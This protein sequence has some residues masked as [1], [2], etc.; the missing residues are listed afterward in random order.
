VAG[1]ARQRHQ[2]LGFG[3]GQAPLIGKVLEYALVLPRCRRLRRQRAAGR[4]RG[5]DVCGPALAA[6]G[7]TCDAW[8][9]TGGVRPHRQRPGLD[10]RQAQR[11]RAGGQQCGQG[12]GG[13]AGVLQGCVPLGRPG[14]GQVLDDARERVGAQIGVGTERRQR[15]QPRHPQPGRA[16]PGELGVQEGAVEGQ[17]VRY[18]QGS[19]HQPQQRPRDLRERR[20][21]RDV[22]VADPVQ[23]LVVPRHPPL[24]VDQGGKLLQH[25]A[26]GPQPH[27]RDLAYPVAARRIQAGGL[28]ID[29]RVLNPSGIDPI[30]SPPQ[31]HRLEHRS[32]RPFPTYHTTQRPPSSPITRPE[33]PPGS[34]GRPY[35]DGTNLGADRPAAGARVALPRR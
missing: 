25:R 21:A 33:A 7:K 10:A 1:R 12:P 26:V 17:V 2:L 35:T 13:V 15:A 4:Q 20:R 27:R 32:T 28:H 31:E 16:G 3:S 30:K 18:H 5:A 6:A 8:L 14:P 11:L 22:L 29:D 19:A 34:P 24:R 9:G 23:G